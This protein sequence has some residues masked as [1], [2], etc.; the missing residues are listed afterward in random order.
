MAENGNRCPTVREWKGDPFICLFSVI[1]N[2]A[3]I[4]CGRW[5]VQRTEHIHSY[6][7]A[8]IFWTPHSRQSGGQWSNIIGRHSISVSRQLDSMWMLRL[9]V[10]RVCAE[11]VRQPNSCFRAALCIISH[12]LRSMVTFLRTL[13]RIQSVADRTGAPFCGTL[14]RCHP[15]SSQLWDTVHFSSQRSGVL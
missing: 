4:I 11:H 3:A 5:P 14:L 12:T 15:H 7:Q 10:V 8:R 2:P 9:L 1:A 13:R 6:A